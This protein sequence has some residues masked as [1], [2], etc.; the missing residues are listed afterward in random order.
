MAICFFSVIAQYSQVH[1]NVA[2]LTASE[3]PA[4]LPADPMKEA[5]AQLEKEDA[6]REQVLK[7]EEALEQHVKLQQK[8]TE[9]E[10]LREA[11]AEYQQVQMSRR[12]AATL[13]ILPE[14]APFFIAATTFT[15][16]PQGVL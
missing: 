5:A 9:L 14:D 1:H 2:E 8:Q 3:V 7:Q 15:V 6:E 13:S 12:K 4:P 16:S 11:E 10:E